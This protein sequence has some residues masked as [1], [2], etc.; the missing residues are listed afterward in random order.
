MSA[1]HTVNPQLQP[2]N[3]RIHLITPAAHR[4]PKTHLFVHTVRFWSMAAII[5]MHSQP[6]FRATHGITQAHLQL[7]LQPFKFGTIGFFLISGFLM[8][9]RLQTSKPLDYLRRRLAAIFT[10]WL[11]WFMLAAV[12]LYVADIA[13]HRVLLINSQAALL[14]FLHEME[15]CVRGTSY[16]FVPNLLVG[17]SILLLFRKHLSSLRF[18]GLLL[19]INLFYVI[20]I[21]MRWFPSAHSDATFGF[22]FYL[23][24]GA[25]SARHIDRLQRAVA[26]IPLAL[27]L[28]LVTGIAAC[29]E[30]HLLQRLYVLD[31]TNTLRLSNQLFSVAVVLLLM[32]LRSATWPRLID[33]PSQTFGLYLIHPLVLIAIDRTLQRTLPPPASSIAYLSEWAMCF[34]VAYTASLFVTKALLSVPRLR[35]LVGGKAPQGA[36]KRLP[37]LQLQPRT[38]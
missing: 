24:L 36:K 5:A 7:M 4:A 23:W 20:N 25:W 14:G 31:P 12:Y 16:W 37:L 11:F 6:P 26:D 1:A 3:S 38:A 28:G 22:V 2:V 15:Y 29:G 9:D 13:H 27:H 8:G 34:G 33:V 21:Y 17:M 30:I 18:G 19:A 35:S 10:P 32:R